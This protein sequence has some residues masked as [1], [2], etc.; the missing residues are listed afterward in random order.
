M[1]GKI[2]NRVKSGRALIKLFGA[3]S[4]KVKKYMRNNKVYFRSAG[5]NEIAAV[6]RYYDTL[7]AAR[8]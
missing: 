7:A 2:F 4:D 5:K 8:K 3:E 1:V 6:L